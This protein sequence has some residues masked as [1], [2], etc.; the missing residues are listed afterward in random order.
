MCCGCRKDGK[1][2]KK[3]RGIGV[4]KNN[5]TSTCFYLKYFLTPRCPGRRKWGQMTLYFCST[6]PRNSQL[7]RYDGLQQIP[8]SAATELPHLQ[9]ALGA[10]HFVARWIM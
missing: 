5:V 6:D 9:P 4:N 3:K 7:L 10:G 8:V 2:K 1:R